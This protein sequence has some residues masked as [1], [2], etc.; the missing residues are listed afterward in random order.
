M[1]WSFELSLNIVARSRHPGGVH[2]LFCD[3]SV[4]FVSDSV[5]RAVWR[6]LGTRNGQE[7][8]SNTD[9]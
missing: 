7:E 9:F 3:G 2:C 5:D 4:K 6:A 1:S 8:I